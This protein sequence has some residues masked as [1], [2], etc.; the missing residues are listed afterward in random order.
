MIYLDTNILLYATLSKVDTQS[1]KDKAIEILRTAV[2]NQT[3]IL[4]NL[5]LLEYTFVMKK[6][7]ENDQKIESTLKIF[8]TFVKEENNKFN[9]I[10]MNMLNDEY[11]Y[12]N[13]F[14]VYHVAFAKA[15]GCDDLF[16]FDKG[17]GKFTD[18]DDMNIRVLI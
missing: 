10:L 2:K 14:D 17:F 4:S 6:S 16:T 9:L 7:K 8:Q 3:L 5:N 15:C 18:I 13:S 11:A 1:Q 12:K